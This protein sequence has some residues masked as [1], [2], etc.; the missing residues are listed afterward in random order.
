M[1]GAVVTEPTNT[2]ERASAV[3]LERRDDAA[4]FFRLL[5]G[6]GRQQRLCRSRRY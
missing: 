4:C 2:M 3:V 5:G 1:I 6:E